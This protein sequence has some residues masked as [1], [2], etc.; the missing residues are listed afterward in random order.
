MTNPATLYRIS[1][2]GVGT[3]GNFVY[4]SGDPHAGAS[5]TISGLAYSNNFLG[6]KASVLYGIDSFQ[7]TLVTLDLPGDKLKTVGSLG[8]ITN[9]RLG[10][11]I[12]GVS[13]IAYAALSAFGTGTT[14]YTV[15]LTTGAA[16]QKADIGPGSPPASEVVVDITSLPRTH[17]ANI[18]TRSQVA[19]GENVMIAG[20]IAP[21]GGNSARLII[22]GLGPSLAA[23]GV[24][25]PLADPLLSIV[26]G[27]GAE[28]ASNDN[29]RSPAANQTA[30]QQTGIPPSDDLEAAYVGD[31]PA[32]AYTAILSGKDG[33]TGVGAVEVYQLR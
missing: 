24:A 1:T 11:E 2:N 13:G 4:A 28:I 12:S 20:F 6:A 18:S 29:W 19:G 22:R 15:D 16:T 26:D 25:S 21:G 10:F 5:P 31:F 33:G 32:G 30:V 27:N 3:D 14:L 7:A 23:G 9:R 17:L 8:L